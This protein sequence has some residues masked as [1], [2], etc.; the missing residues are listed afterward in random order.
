MAV[1][2]LPGR[3]GSVT[4]MSAYADI[5]A[6]LE[7]RIR[8]GEFPP[9]SLLPSYSKAAAHYSVS[10]TTVQSAYRL[11]R[12]RKLTRA[13]NGEGTYVADSISGLGT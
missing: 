5:A 11:L 7:Q 10:V 13:V 3:V 2:D 6:D 1:I 8:S 12:D 4:A 9:G